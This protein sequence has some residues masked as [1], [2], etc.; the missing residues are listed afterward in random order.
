MEGGR[1]MAAIRKT[2]GRQGKRAARRTGARRPHPIHSTGGSRMSGAAAALQRRRTLQLAV[3]GAIFVA[4]VAWKLLFP[5]SLWS[6]AG[7]VREALGQDADFKAAFSAVGEAIAGEK[8]VGDSLQE[9]YT[10]VFAPTRYHAQQASATLEAVT[11]VTLPADRLR[12]ELEDT[13]MPRET[14]ETDQE[15][16]QIADLPGGHGSADL[17]RGTP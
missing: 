1:T 16:R 3:A 12:L 5:E 7:A 2:S 11:Q 10:A 9:A 15:E 6:V 13:L 14:G 17:E 8:E 4:L